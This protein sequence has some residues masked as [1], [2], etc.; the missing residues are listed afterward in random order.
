MDMLLQSI[1]WKCWI[2][3]STNDDSPVKDHLI[4]YGMVLVMVLLMLIM[5][6]IKEWAI[7]ILQYFYNIMEAIRNPIWKNALKKMFNSFTNHIYNKSIFK[8][9]CMNHAILSGWKSLWSF[10]QIMN[11][12]NCIAVD[13]AY[14]VWYDSCI[15]DLQ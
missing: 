6:Y 5:D 2:K 12:W 14:T 10:H 9:L 4:I 13:T 7:Y 1:I 8:L 3:T 15:W 11:D